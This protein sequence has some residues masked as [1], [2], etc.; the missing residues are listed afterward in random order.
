MTPLEFTWMRLIRMYPLY[1]LGTARGILALLLSFDRLLWSGS[2]AHVIAHPMLAVALALFMLP[3]FH[4]YA[5]YIFNFRH[6]RYFL[7]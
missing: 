3:D 1:I 6:G 2:A 4:A 5:E 7:K